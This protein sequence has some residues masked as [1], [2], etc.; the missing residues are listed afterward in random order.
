LDTRSKIKYL[1]AKK[2]LIPKG[3]DP[4]TLRLRMEGV[5][6]SYDVFESAQFKKIQ[7]VKDILQD[8]PHFKLEKGD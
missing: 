1:L 5:T 4:S 6:Q 7:I 8:N 2:D 3:N